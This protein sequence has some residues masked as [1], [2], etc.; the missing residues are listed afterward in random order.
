VTGPTGSTG[1]TGAGQF[2]VSPTAPTGASSTDVWYNSTNGRTYLYYQDVDGVQW[3]EFGNS[4]L[5]PTGPTG[6]TGIP[7]SASSTGATGPTGYTGPAG[8]GLTTE[9]TIV[10]LQVY[11]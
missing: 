9:D 2:I 4:N 1:A 8:I 11:R 7:G 5:G 3:V 6:P 10:G